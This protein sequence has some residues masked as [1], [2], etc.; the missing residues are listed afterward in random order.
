MVHELL[1]RMTER[2]NDQHFGKYRATVVDNKDPQKLGRIRVRVDSLLV[3]SEDRIESDEIVTDWATP[4][5]PCGGLA[6]QGFF[7][8][9]EQDAKVWVEF[10]EGNLDRP[11]WVGS[12][13]TSQATPP[14][15]ALNMVGTEQDRQPKRRVLKTSSGHVLEFSDVDGKEAITLR[16][17]DGATLQLD[18]KGSA[19][20]INKEGS[21]L[22][23]NADSAE[24][25][26]IHQNGANLTMKGSAVTITNSEGTTV[27]VSGSAVQV[28][29]DSVHVR[30][31]TVVIGEGAVEPAVLGLAL[32]KIFDT[33][34]HTCTG[35]GSPSSPPMP[36]NLIAIPTNMVLSQSVKVK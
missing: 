12:F 16:H 27:D 13:W 1:A 25:T 3:D 34:V 33:H 11:L 9:P 22:Y 32:A 19:L 28:I 8:V 5:L 4:C 2:L 18:E 17:K 30:S 21:H 10:E 15:E 36:P 29:A 6:D 35:P 7:F 24:T 23:M 31:Q 26:L 14:A 20:L